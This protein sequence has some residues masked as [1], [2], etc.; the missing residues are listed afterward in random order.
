IFAEDTVEYAGQS[1]FAVVAESVDAARRA[2]RL[3]VV[4]YEDLEPILD[5]KTALARQSFV[6]PTRTLKRGDPDA[7]LRSAPHRMSGSF[8]VGGQEH[9]YLEGQIAVALPGEDGTMLIHSSTQHPSE[10]QRLVAHCLGV[11][12]KDVFVHCRRMGGGRSAEHT[13]ELQS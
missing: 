2:T 1:L 10:V 9:F 12:A 6:M 4:E 5:V 7:K 8:S 11:S 3:A 13:S